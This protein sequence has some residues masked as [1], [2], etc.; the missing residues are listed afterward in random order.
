M[1]RCQKIMFECHKIK[2][3]DI[4]NATEKGSTAII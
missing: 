3:Y 4:S 2:V 1:V